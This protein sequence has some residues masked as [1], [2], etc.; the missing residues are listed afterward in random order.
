MR[1]AGINAASSFAGIPQECCK[2]VIFP[3][4]NYVIVAGPSGDGLGRR[5]TNGDNDPGEY[6]GAI[7]LNRQPMRRSGHGAPQCRR[8]LVNCN[9]SSSHTR[10]IVNGHFLAP[11]PQVYLGKPKPRSASGIVMT[12][13]LIFQELES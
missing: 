8:G 11:N 3:N 1:S 12:G 13:L 2:G 9:S 6:R 4:A 5:F 10:G 7:I